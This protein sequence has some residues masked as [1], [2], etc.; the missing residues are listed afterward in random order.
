MILRCASCNTANRRPEGHEHRRITG[1]MP[2]DAIA[3]GVGI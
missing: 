1:A 3:Q 2:A